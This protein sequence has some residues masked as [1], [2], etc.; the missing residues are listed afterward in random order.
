MAHVQREVR[1]R[2]LGMMSAAT[3]DEPAGKEAPPSSRTPSRAGG[4]R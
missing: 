1:E 2:L 4:P 3:S